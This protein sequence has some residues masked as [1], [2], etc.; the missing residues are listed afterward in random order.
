[1]VYFFYYVPVGINAELRKVPIQTY[2]YAG[3]CLVVFA[4]EKFAGGV[5]PFDFER[6]AYYPDTGTLTTALSATFLHVGYLHL[7]GNLV[8]LVLLGRYVEDRLGGLLF[9]TLFF[10]CAATG[11]LLQGVFNTA[12]LHEPQTGVVG[13]SGAVAGILGAVT[14]RF[15]M[16]KL[17]IA[18]WVFMPLQAF[19]RAGKTELPVVFA[20]VFWFALEF[21]RGLLQAGGY[22][23]HQ[24]PP[25][26]AGE[27]MAPP[28]WTCVSWQ[29][30]QLPFSPAC[31]NLPT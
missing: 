28:G 17:R 2:A 14:V 9:S 6:L 22:V 7:V 26:F 10:G 16:N 1:M 20:V 11:A 23:P 5:I 12:V 29:L 19:T 8:Y 31:I 27:P 25:S 21:F 24:P 18:Y 3:L 13:A 4:L 30:V 15:L